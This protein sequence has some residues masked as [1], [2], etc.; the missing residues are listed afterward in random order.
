[1]Q[2]RTSGVVKV[3]VGCCEDAERG[4]RA[5]R[6][7]HH[8]RLAPEPLQRP[9]AGDRAHQPRAAHHRRPDQGRVE[10]PVE[11]RAGAEQALVVVLLQDRRRVVADEGVAGELVEEDERGDGGRAA[12]ERQRG[13]LLQQTD[14]VFAFC[15]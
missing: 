9:D 10:H 7:E 13:R 2:S 1:M 6:G 5:Q 11:G 14:V 12:E 4:R 3:I 15:S 8:E